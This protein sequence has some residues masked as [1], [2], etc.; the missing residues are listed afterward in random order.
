MTVIMEKLYAVASWEASP[1]LFVLCMFTLACLVYS[2]FLLLAVFLLSADEASDCIG[3]LLREWRP[4]GNDRP[5]CEPS[6]RERES[7]GL[8]APMGR[9]PTVGQRHKACL[10]GLV[11]H[12][13]AVAFDMLVI[14]L[15]L[16]ATGLV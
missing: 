16:K 12:A 10:T 5:L 6:P 13:M 1:F 11:L 3:R 9:C 7:S 14:G 15:V 2:L 4:G 8:C